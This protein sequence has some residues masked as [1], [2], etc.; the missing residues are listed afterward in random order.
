[1]NMEIKECKKCSRKFVTETDF[2]TGTSRWRICD[3]G[4]LWFN[5]SCQSTMMLKKGKFPWYSPDKVMSKEAASVF[6]QLATLKNLPHLPQALM[7]L[8]TLLGDDNS[9]SGQIVQAL[10]SNALIAGNVLKTANN[11]KFCLCIPHVN[12]KQ[13]DDNEYPREADKRT[14]SWLVV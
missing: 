6:N 7:K 13:Q 9:T 4:N 2:F 12:F 14:N 3:M 10:R 11:L 5:C 1:M 8:Q